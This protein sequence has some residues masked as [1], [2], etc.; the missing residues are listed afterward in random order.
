[1]HY[2][3]VRKITTPEELGVNGDTVGDFLL[4]LQ[5]KLP[6][7]PLDIILPNGT[8]LFL[9]GEKI[10]IKLPKNKEIRPD[11]IEEIITEGTRLLLEENRE[12]FPGDRRRRIK[13]TM[14]LGDNT[15][16]F[17]QGHLGLSP[18]GDIMPMNP[19]LQRTDDTFIRMLDNNFTSDMGKLEFLLR[20][21]HNSTLGSREEDRTQEIA[22]KLGFVTVEKDDSIIDVEINGVTDPCMVTRLCIHPNQIQNEKE[23][24]ESAIKTY[25]DIL[26]L[27]ESPLLMIGLN[28]YIDITIGRDRKAI[29][30]E[31]ENCEISKIIQKLVKTVIGLILTKDALENVKIG[32]NESILVEGETLRE[33]ILRRLDETIEAIDKTR[34]RHG[35]IITLYTTLVTI[36]LIFLFFLYSK[37]NP[38]NSYLQAAIATIPPVVFSVMVT[39]EYRKLTWVKTFGQ[40]KFP[41]YMWSLSIISYIVIYTLG[42]DAYFMAIFYITVGVVGATILVVIRNLLIKLSPQIKWVFSPIA[43]LLFLMTRRKYEDKIE[44]KE[45]KPSIFQSETMKK[46]GIT[47]SNISKSGTGK[48]I[49]AIFS[50]ILRVASSILGVIAVIIFAVAFLPMI[51]LFVLFN[52]L[53]RG[54]WRELEKYREDVI[55]KAIH[56]YR[57]QRNLAP[58]CRVIFRTTK[59]KRLKNPLSGALKVLRKKAPRLL[60]A[61]GFIDLINKLVFKEWM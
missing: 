60:T 10:E 15:I 32:Y 43:K 9:G 1:M 55:E 59:C 20:R 3:K 4:D 34:E 14:S 39:R 16:Y 42:Y 24:L 30:I 11:I 5:K 6:S 57:D 37:T 19:I 45:K 31:P 12:R 36:P 48:K 17:T 52:F 47:L 58:S 27:G 51:G 29:T 2:R 61:D 41:I 33:Q 56:K 50:I 8:K 25:R 28:N 13:L 53:N 40:K 46:I 23:L 44:H 38:T 7:Y 35:H 26:A 22:E 21:Q 18:G 49:W 54:Y